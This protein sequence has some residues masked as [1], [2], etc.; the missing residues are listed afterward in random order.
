MRT[1]ALITLNLL[2]YPIVGVWILVGMFMCFGVFTSP[3]TESEATRS[4][5]I[6][7]LGIAIGVGNVA[8]S[9]YWLIRASSRRKTVRKSSNCV[10]CG[11][12]VNE[13]AKFCV[14]CGEAMY[15]PTPS[16][17][18]PEL[19]SSA[20]G[21]G[22]RKGN[23][24]Q[25]L[26]EYAN[27][28]GRASREE[29]WWFTLFLFGMFFLIN[30]VFLVGFAVVSALGDAGAVASFYVVALQGLILVTALLLLAVTIRRLHDTGR[31]G[32]WVLVILVSFVGQI[33]WPLGLV[34]AWLWGL[35]ILVSFVG[36]VPLLIFLLLPSDPGP[37]EYGR[38]PGS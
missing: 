30:I 18:R 16:A 11:S 10:S 33:S 14:R 3:C 38:G 13:D 9:V 15:G 5:Y 23:F 34:P 19:A 8:W 29:F 27:V 1:A 20:P 17:A 4:V 31:S 2:L 26:K 35:V 36:W 7:L 28:R 37:N 24:V 32:W 12:D 25:G 21:D 22:V 6:F